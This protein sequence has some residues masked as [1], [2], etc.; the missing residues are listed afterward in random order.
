[1]VRVGCLAEP[2]SDPKALTEK[3]SA[4]CAPPALPLS[5]NAWVILKGLETLKSVWK[6]SRQTRFGWPWP[7]ASRRWR[8]FSIRGSNRIRSTRWRCASK[9]AAVP[10]SVSEI[11]GGR[12]AAWQLV[13]NC[14]VMSITANLGDTKTTITHPASTTHGRISAEARAQ[15]AIEEGCCASPWGS[16]RS[17]TCRPISL[18]DCACSERRRSPGFASGGPRRGP[19]AQFRYGTYSRSTSVPQ[20]HSR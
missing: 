2:W 13:D 18:A 10:S 19:C 14:K 5:F 3:C 16:S 4:S 12:A 20:D 15:A 8:G 7:N 17:T 11:T 1:M 6:P 9:A